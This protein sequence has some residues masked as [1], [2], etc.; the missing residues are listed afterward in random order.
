[1]VNIT[2][3]R[4]DENETCGFRIEGH[5]GFDKKGRDIVCAA[6]SVL[7][8]NTVNS[9]EKFTKDRFSAKIDDNGG[10]LEFILVDEISKESKLLL[11]SFYLGIESILDE[12]GEKF[13]RL[14]K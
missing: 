14:I 2:T 1:M 9:V 3:I 11:D 8:Q 12:Y 6:V 4:N 13:L 10:F 5:A 7:A